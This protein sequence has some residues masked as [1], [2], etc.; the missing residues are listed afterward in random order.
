MNRIHRIALLFGWLTLSLTPHQCGHAAVGSRALEVQQTG[1]ITGRVQNVA[2]GQYLNHAR[3]TVRG[4]DQVVFTDESGT[5]LLSTLPG[6][7]VVL[8]V[9]YT[10]LDAQEITVPVTPGQTTVQDVEMT[11]AARYGVQDGTVK[12][13]MG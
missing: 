11:S 8:G 3:I 4:T 5:Y 1:G 2:T 13:A 12:L 7:P 9:F 6:G 10:G